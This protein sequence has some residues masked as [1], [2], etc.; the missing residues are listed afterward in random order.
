M[1]QSTACSKLACNTVHFR[2]ALHTFTSYVHFTHL[3]ACCALPMGSHFTQMYY[4][5]GSVL[6]IKK[7]SSTFRIMYICTPTTHCLV[8]GYY[9]TVVLQYSSTSFYN[10][11]MQSCRVG[12]CRRKHLHATTKK[13]SL[14]PC[15]WW[16]I[17]VSIMWTQ[18]MISAISQFHEDE[19]LH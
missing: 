6:L 9:G 2:R 19:E 4:G 5:N 18:C 1:H 16:A 10:L 8:Y 11:V 15:M 12:L 7:V 13:A 3:H 14:P 17:Y